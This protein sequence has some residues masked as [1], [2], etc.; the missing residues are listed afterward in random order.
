MDL[1]PDYTAIKDIDSKFGGS[2]RPT[3]N[4]I[5]ILTEIIEPAKSKGDDWYLSFSVRDDD[6]ASQWRTDPSFIRC[7]LFRRERTH[8]PTGKVGDPVIVRGV[9]V[10]LYDGVKEG[11]CTSR[12][13]Q[14]LFFPAD[15][16]PIPELSTAYGYGGQSK[17]PFNGSLQ[18]SGNREA[19]APSILEQLAIIGIKAK[20]AACGTVLKQAAKPIAVSK[21]RDRH[22]LIKD[23]QLDNFYELVVE[24][25][26]IYSVHDGADGVDLY[27]SDYTT[28]K[29]LFLYEP[30][31]TNPSSKWQG[32]FGQVTMS[33]RLWEPHASWARQDLREGDWIRLKN[34]RIK[35][36][37]ANKI[38]GSLHADQTY[39]D[40]ILISK[41]DKSHDAEFMQEL[42]AR[43]RA[44]LEKYEREDTAAEPG[45]HATKA[46]AKAAAKKKSARK[47]RE[48]QRK[49]EEQRQLEK[50]AEAQ[51][52]ARSNINGH[53]IA[54][55][56]E[57]RLSSIDE[58]LDDSHRTMQTRD[59]GQLVFP[60]VNAKYRTRVRVVDFFPHD[61]HDFSRCMDDPTWN[62]P[63]LDQDRAHGRRDDRWQWGFVLF[64]EDATSTRP[65]PQRIPLFV[66]NDSGQYL[67]NIDAIDLRN[68]AR[69]RTMATLEEKLFIL[70]GNLLELKR[71]LAPSGV[72]FPLPTRDQRL[73]NKPFECCIEEYGV[74][75]EPSPQWPTGWQR[76]YKLAST[77][78]RV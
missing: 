71:D 15:K 28:N 37:P 31:D 42:G 51:A 60:F 8:L 20:A 34:V 52:V 54:S 26:K 18:L 12:Q 68:D 45:G 40:K 61:L 17:L 50:E 70:W 27:V 43:K 1:P 74:Q 36:S 41:L 49:E 16:V 5:G 72:K 3:V 19:T 35:S 53:V 23:V 63:L 73:S 30:P 33:V 38:E 32:P 39:P 62:T 56:P 21:P 6:F 69:G 25:V 13:S 78:I 29:A 59:G 55:H 47:A 9:Q 22:S 2:G 77:L 67:L 7:R 48:R 11:V 76:I 65:T 44:Y 24:T 58:I 14:V 4:I 66:F 75:V 10:H 46:S 64:V 57:I